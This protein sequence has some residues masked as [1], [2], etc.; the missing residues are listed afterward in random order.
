L[1]YALLIFVF[2]FYALF[3]LQD[4]QTTDDVV[5]TDSA[6]IIINIGLTNKRINK[7]Q[8]KVFSFYSIKVSLDV[9]KKLLKASQIIKWKN[10]S[11]IPTSELYFHLYPNAFS[12]NHTE[13]SEGR[14]IPDNSLSH[15]FIK[16]V[17]VNDQSKRLQSSSG[18]ADNP[19]DSTVAKIILDQ[20][21]NQNDS[22]LIAFEYEVKIPKAYSRFGYDANENFFFLAQWFPKIGVY[23][24]GRWV[25]DPYYPFTE[26]YADFSNY[27][28]EIT[29]PNGFV[30]A[31]S[32]EVKEKQVDKYNTTYKVVQKNIHDFA[33]LAA[34]DVLNFIDTVKRKDH[35]EVFVHYILQTT[36]EDAKER[37]RSAVKNAFLFFDKNI[38]RYPYKMLTVIDAPTKAGTI[39]AMEYPALFTFSKDYFSPEFTKDVEEVILHEFSHQYFYGMVANNETTEA[40]LDEG[41]AEYLSQK[42]L[43]KRYGERFASFKLFGYLPVT[44]MELLSIEKIPFIYTLTQI[45][46]PFEADLMASYYPYAM[47]GSLKDTSYKLLNKSVY[48][49]V[50]YAKGALFL[51][52]LEKYLGEQK[53]FYILRQY[54]AS[55]KYK[56][57]TAAD[58]FSVL[59]KY[60]GENIEWLIT[61][62]YEN[63]FTCDYRI[64]GITCSA[65]KHQ[66]EVII[67]RD[68]EAIVPLEVVLY[69]DKDT[70]KTF[71][72]GKEKIKKLIFHTSNKVL[73]AEI[74]PG[75]KNLFDLNFANNSYTLE[76][77]YSG[78]LYIS[79]RWFFWVQNLLM[80]FGGLS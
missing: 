64:M 78:S 35:S 38:G 26:F 7:E 69:T 21:V 30:F 22:V 6:S 36:N 74:D 34:K 16:K 65:E 14:T 23:E 45:P 39:R 60:S 40:W 57:P 20:P 33:W 27:A 68:G 46:K 1:K 62:F 80:I 43:Q 31:S 52:T 71:W 47:F 59:R 18:N 4:K 66:T 3:Q 17:T 9:Q 11:L 72:D 76:T 15:I 77:E 75:R 61:G 58:F 2:L 13:F 51:F 5:L 12:N 54:F 28:L 32:G 41:F 67:V 70:L 44:G 29:I 55:Y 49:S 73:A 56:H 25:C 24:N 53:L 10:P 19:F 79:V 50:S 8:P 42:I 37:I 48:Q 63:S